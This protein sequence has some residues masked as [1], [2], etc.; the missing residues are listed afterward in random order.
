MARTLA[1]LLRS[2]RSDQKKPRKPHAGI[3]E[4]FLPNDRRKGARPGNE[5]WGALKGWRLYC[6]SLLRDGCLFRQSRLR[7]ISNEE[8]V[9]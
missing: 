2:Q 7:M 6:L 8:S 3:P 5:A 9:E 4:R 1:A